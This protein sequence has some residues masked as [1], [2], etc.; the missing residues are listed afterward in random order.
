MWNPCNTY[1][2]PVVMGYLGFKYEGA[3]KVWIPKIGIREIKDITF[4]EDGLPVLTMHD[5]VRAS[6]GEVRGPRWRPL[7]ARH[8]FELDPA[9]TTAEGETV[10]VGPNKLCFGPQRSAC[11]AGTQAQ[12]RIKEI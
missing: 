12:R 11:A 6:I 2:G 9:T 1:N 4:Y 10:E 8:H 7:S 5:G 3:Y